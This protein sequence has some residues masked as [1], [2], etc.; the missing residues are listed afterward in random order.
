MIK[1]FLILNEINQDEDIID[2]LKIDTEK[3]ERKKTLEIINL[4]I[5]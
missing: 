1:V 5:Q 3:S 2:E 4:L